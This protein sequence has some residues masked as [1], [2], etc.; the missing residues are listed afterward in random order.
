MAAALKHEFGNHDLWAIKDPRLCRLLPWWQG[1][2]SE[3][4]WRAV[5]A[6]LIRQPLEVAASLQKRDGFSEQRGVLLWVDYTLQ[7]LFWTQGYPRV[8]VTF[9]ELMT[10]PAETATKIL[11]LV[12]PKQRPL[13]ASRYPELLQGFLDPGLRH[14]Q[15]DDRGVDSAK[16]NE[17]LI[18]GACELY[19]RLVDWN[20]GHAPAIESNELGRWMAWRSRMAAANAAILYEQLQATMRA[21]GAAE[22]A[23]RQ[24]YRSAS[25][26]MGK[27]I[28]VAG[29]LMN[30]I[31]ER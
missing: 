17:G 13:P 10:G 11:E 30:R 14:Y 22:L 24:M 3:S 7:S 23:R 26:R 15:R 12:E 6:L 18:E 4:R 25:W 8:L 20:L 31:K 29:R 19:R 16:G 5:Y 9:D 21:Y 28:R 2:L 1:L 27:P